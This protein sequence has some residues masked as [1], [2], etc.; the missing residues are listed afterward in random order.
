MNIH[1]DNVDLKSLSGPNSFAQ[2]LIKYASKSDCTFD[3]DKPANIHLCFIE[4]HRQFF[5]APMSQRLDGIYFNT[6]S[7]YNI[8]NANIRRTYEMADGVIFQ[9]YFNKEL[10]TKYFGPHENWRIIHNGADT[11][12]IEKT[13][14]MEHPILDK[15]EN[16]WMCASNWRPHKR[17]NENV[18]YFLEYSGDN[19]C[20]V[21]AG[22]GISEKFSKH[23]R[24][25][26]VGAVD[27]ETLISLYK[28]SKYFLHLAWLDH[29]PNVVVDAR[30]S[31]CQIVCSDSGGTKEIAGPD[32]ILIREKIWNLE[33]LDLY[34]PP[35]LDFTKNLGNVCAQ[36][37]DM[38]GCTSKYKS[39]FTRI[40]LE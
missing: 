1:L 15:F 20:L 33:P 12:L 30:A 23:S 22:D 24:V 27:R 35:K 10:I 18:R 2:K 9:S 14:P 16:T 39:F 8:Q 40:T 7:D 3:V 25:F 4:T 37:Y 29:C 26:A 17:L 5:N 36:S 6:R 11:E 38:M 13:E 28:R 19:D 31:G 21:I 32:A 34:S